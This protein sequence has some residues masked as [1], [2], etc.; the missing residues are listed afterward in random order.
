M[1][2][3]GVEGTDA[4]LQAQ[5]NVEESPADSTPVVDAKARLAEA[6]AA[7]RQLAVFDEVVGTQVGQ[8]GVE[9]GLAHR[10][11]VDDALQFQLVVLAIATLPEGKAAGLG[12]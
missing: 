10:V 5:V 11:P 12:L 3:L 6:I 9:R 8:R 7:D 1:I 2:T 4:I